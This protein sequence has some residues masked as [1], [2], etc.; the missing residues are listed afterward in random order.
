MGKMKRKGRIRIFSVTLQS[1]PY[2]TRKKLKI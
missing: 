1:F 2:T